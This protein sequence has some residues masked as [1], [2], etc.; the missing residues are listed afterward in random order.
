MKITH[1]A[2]TDL[3]SACRLSAHIS[4]VFANE[5]TGGTTTTIDDLF[6][7][8]MD[9]LYTMNNESAPD[10]RSSAVYELLFDTSLSDEQVADTLLH[11]TT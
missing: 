8:I 4:S 5:I 1:S 2:L 6:G 11:P 3:I 10:L 9:A 7:H